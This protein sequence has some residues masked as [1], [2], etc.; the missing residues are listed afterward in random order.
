MDMENTIMEVTVLAAEVAI[1]SFFYRLYKSKSE[2]LQ[3]LT[4]AQCFELS[5]NLKEN[6]QNKGGVIPYA[7][8]TGNIKALA[9]P[10]KSQHFSHIRGVIR[11]NIIQ[12]NKVRWIPF[13]RV[14]S[15][16]NNTIQQSM[17]SV[18]FALSGRSGLF[19][20]QVCVEVIDPLVAEE[21]DIPVIYNE[22]TSHQET[23]GEAL[24][25][26]FRGER[27]V[28]IQNIE[29]VLIEDTNLTAVG[30]LVIEDDALKIKPPDVGTYF[31]TPS[32]F[33]SLIAKVNG[34][35]KALKVFTYFLG[36]I[37]FFSFIYVAKKAGSE[38]K[39]RRDAAA[40]RKML[41]EAKK[42]RREEMSEDLA[43]SEHMPKCVICLSKP[44]EVVILTCG[45]ACLCID[46]SERMT[47]FSSN[48]CPICREVIDHLA[49]VYLP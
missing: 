15:S 45:H 8:I 37:S 17:T 31:L 7:V 28:G 3:S 30:Q 13:L 12:E 36:I 47:E 46:C 35:T 19:R 14:W 27:T 42:K 16:T 40:Y 11:E 44:V 24:V 41:E 33:E 38:F 6:V 48:L 49:P 4:E 34:T 18:P 10:L 9:T 20:K 5:P 22:F 32:T 26:F 1:F 39:R 25:D 23:F 29:R 2:C 43:T 21:L